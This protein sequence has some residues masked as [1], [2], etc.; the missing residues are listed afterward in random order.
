MLLTEFASGQAQPPRLTLSQQRDDFAIFRGSLEEGHGG[1]YYFIDKAT[2]ARQCD[3]IGKTF[4]EGITV[5]GYYL[6]L[7]YLL[8]LLRYGHSRINLP[9]EGEPNYWLNNLKK[10]RRYLPLQLMVIDQK[11][12]VLG[13]CSEEQRVSRG[14][15][16]LSIN[17]KP[18][19]QLLD[20][21]ARYIPADGI[22]QT[23]KTYFLYKYYYLHF[24]Y[25]MLYP[26]EM[27]FSLR[28]A[29][30]PKPVRV[31]AQLPSAME[32]AHKM[33]TGKSLSHFEN[34]TQYKAVVAPQTAYL[35]VGS[36]YK[37]FI[38][39]FGVRFETFVDSAFRDM[40][41]RSTQHL[42]I[43]LR[44][45]EG[46]SDGYSEKLL[47][48]ITPSPILPGQMVVP[49][50]TF[51]FQQYA[52]NLSDDIKGYI[53]DPAEF[54][55]DDKTLFIKQKYLDMM[56]AT[57]LPTKDR[58]TG[59]IVVLIN[60]GVFSAGAGF[61]EKLYKYR[62]TTGQKIT[63]VGEELGSDIYAG[64]LCA[65]QSYIIKL[66]NSAITVDMPF[67]CWGEFTK[68]YP[69]KRL[70]DYRVLPT[71]TG[72]LQGHDE[73]LQFVLDRISKND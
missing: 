10:D 54:L 42:I 63:F 56:G 32:K 30:Q 45:N 2:F 39:N 11:L 38:E 61:V 52:I 69:A 20:S 58:F 59:Q 1:L 26:N 14:A 22:N 53:A 49:S 19:R 48:H 64:I 4:R 23:F 44:D 60:E 5:D 13:D 16:I 7:R 18:A 6:K 41:S 17:G 46:G 66:P 43:D 72:L 55:R 27:E 29:G 37:G 28:L 31:K 25:N 62:Q 50:K 35:K 21:M 51:P 47:A 33:L 12:Y 9:G 3:S 8:T 40:N 36:F 70:P 24:L 15:E 71:I 67:L 65:G 73:V 34:P 68:K 57:I